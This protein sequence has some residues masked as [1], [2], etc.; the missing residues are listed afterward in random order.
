MSCNFPVKMY[1]TG[2]YTKNGKKVWTSDSSKGY[3][4]FTTVR[5]CGQCL[6]CR[7][8]NSFQN[9]LRSVCEAQLYQYNTFITL[10]V[11][12][13][14]MP[15]VFPGGGL[16]KR[17]WQLFAK[18]LLK[19]YE[20]Y[21][22]VERP[23]WWSCSRNWNNYPIRFLQ[24]GEYGSQLMRPHYHAIIYN[25]QPPTLK[26]W[27]TRAGYTL[28]RSPELEELWPF[29]YSTCCPANFE[30]ASYITR[31]VTKKVTGKMSDEHYFNPLTGE[32][33]Q[34]E[35]LNFPRGYGLGRLWL[36]RYGEAAYNRGF[37]VLKG[38]KTRTPNY[39][40]NIFDLTNPAD[41]ARVRRERKR[42]ALSMDC[43][44]ERLL[45][46]ESIL[47]RR[48]AGKTRSYENGL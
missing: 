38:H 45:A 4:D 44:A 14:Y 46:R 24:C 39:F 33:M 23:D 32:F 42:Q 35:Y 29:G 17:P 3:S 19:K 47:S 27:D 31:Y 1:W 40:D 8:S 6:G 34:P 36:D 15:K 41:V 43:S 18:K 13:E 37:M 10:T 16:S 2:E 7:L 25:W 9:A 21:T 26:P 12:D 28:F 30:T 20:G 22:Y 5:P 48:F 11:S